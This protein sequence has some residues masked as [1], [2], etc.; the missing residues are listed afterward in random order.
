MQ[1]QNRPTE[2]PTAVRSRRQNWRLTKK[3]PFT[4][5]NAH[6]CCFLSTGYSGGDGF[7][8]AR[9]LQPVSTLAQCVIIAL[10]SKSYSPH[11]F[12]GCF[13][14]AQFLQAGFEFAGVDFGAFMNSCV[15]NRN[16]GWHSK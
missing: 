3:S 12:Q 10:R 1:N 14:L 7:Q 9:D 8:P 4:L 16:H 6:S 2:S 15:L 5:S 11:V 13:C